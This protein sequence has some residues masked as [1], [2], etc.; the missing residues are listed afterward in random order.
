MESKLWNPEGHE[1]SEKELSIL[2]ARLVS[3]GYTRYQ[4]KCPNW[5]PPGVWET[6]VQ[7]YNDWNQNRE[8]YYGD[9]S[10]YTP[11]QVSSPLCYD[12]D[13]KWDCFQVAIAC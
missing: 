8:K 4:G 5:C 2:F 7:R 9:R 6:Y 1:P 11:L 13:A 10:K 3:L 12:W